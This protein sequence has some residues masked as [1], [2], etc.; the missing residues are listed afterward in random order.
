MVPITVSPG[1]CGIY[2]ERKDLCMIIMVKT[3]IVTIIIYI[4]VN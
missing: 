4:M 1:L 3:T 2:R